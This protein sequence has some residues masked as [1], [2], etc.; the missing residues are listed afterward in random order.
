MD[1]KQSRIGEILDS[2][3]EMV[4]RGTDRYGPYFI[5]ASEFNSMLLNGMIKS[6]KADRFVFTIFLS[7]VRKYFTLRAMRRLMR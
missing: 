4:I 5:N 3:S 6:I 7:Q 1:F 2:E